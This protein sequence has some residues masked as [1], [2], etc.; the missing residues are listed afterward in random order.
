MTFIRKLRRLSE[1][2]EN[3]HDEVEEICT[4]ESES[5]DEF[6]KSENRRTSFHRRYR[7]HHRQLSLN[8]SKALS[9][10]N[11]KTRKLSLTKTKLWKK[12][13]DDDDMPFDNNS[14]DEKDGEDV[15]KMKG[16]MSCSPSIPLYEITNRNNIEHEQQHDQQYYQKDYETQEDCQKQEK[17]TYQS[18]FNK[19]ERCL[20]DDDDD[21]LQGYQEN[22]D[23]KISKNSKGAA[24]NINVNISDDDNDDDDDDA[25]VNDLL[26]DEQDLPCLDLF[27]GFEGF[28]EE[29]NHEEDQDEQRRQHNDD[30]DDEM[31][32]SREKVNTSQQK[33]TKNGSGSGGGLAIIESDDDDDDDRRECDEEDSLLVQPF[34]TTEAE[35]AGDDDEV[36]GKR[37]TTT[38]EA[39]AAHLG[40]PCTTTATR[41]TKIDEYNHRERIDAKG[42]DDFG[43]KAKVDDIV[44]QKGQSSFI[45]HNQQLSIEQPESIAATKATVTAQSKDYT[46]VGTATAVVSKKKQKIH[47]QWQEEV[48]L[49]DI[50]DDI[51]HDND[52]DDDDDVSFQYENRITTKTKKQ[53]S[54]LAK[55][56]IRTTDRGISLDSPFASTMDTRGMNLSLNHNFSSKS[57]PQDFGWL[58][59]LP[60]YKPISVLTREYGDH[61]NASEPVYVQYKQQFMYNTNKSPS[62][63]GAAGSGGDLSTSKKSRSTKNAD[64]IRSRIQSRKQRSSGGGAGGWSGGCGGNS[65]TSASSLIAHDDDDNDA[66]KVGG[67]KS[68]W[69]HKNGRKTF[70]TANQV[71]TGSRAYKAYQK[72]KGTKGT[73][74]KKKSVGRKKK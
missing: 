26:E 38:A 31:L 7:S 3:K 10:R 57:I 66:D 20:D 59:R 1:V 8:N 21:I 58:E 55:E 30:D 64:K 49:E 16:V 43:E 50:D 71:L 29:E 27:S 13:N 12:N 17:Q 32:W 9:K 54:T 46:L 52:D 72:T 14:V 69:C 68:Y 2:E 63:T 51:I 28:G 42:A 15:D 60:H 36:I 48:L 18:I 47:N 35:E 41:R 33:N 11:T 73:K 24:A 40:A 4:S 70:V 67:G 61:G 53:S 44:Y 19:R 56:T 25:E 23:V 5:D 39:A 74:G 34:G 37:T 62:T 6:R 65:F 22:G 45:F